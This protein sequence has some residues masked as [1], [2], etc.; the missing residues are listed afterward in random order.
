[1]SYISNP[2]AKEISQ[3]PILSE[4]E[5]MQLLRKAKNGDKVAREKVIKHNLRMVLDIAYRFVGSTGIPL[6][7]LISIGSIGLVKAVD[8]F[9]FNYDNNLVT[10]AYEC[11][12]NEI[13]KYLKI[14]HAKKRTG[15]QVIS[16]DDPLYNDTDGDLKYEH[17]LVDNSSKGEDELIDAIILSDAINTLNDDELKIVYH[18]YFIGRKPTSYKEIAKLLGI[19]YQ[20]IQQKEKKLLLKLRSKL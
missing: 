4:S 19:S 11:I 10:L 7:E 1:M 20:A 16:L 15:Q 12:Y 9:N 5:N 8:S 17:I 14:A 2:Y 6:D 13:Y 3:I 18:R